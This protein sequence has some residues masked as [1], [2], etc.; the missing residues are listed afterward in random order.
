MPQSI[1]K[2]RNVQNLTRIYALS[3]RNVILRYK[4]SLIGFLW[5]FI[6]PI[7]Y[8]GIFV[9]IFGKNAGIPHYVLYVTSGLVLWFF[10]SNVTGQ[11]VGTIVGSAGIL[12]SLNIPSYFFPLSEL[13][14]E[15]FNLFLT[16]G[17]FL[18]LMHW[19]GIVYSFRMLL[20]IPC[21][22][23]FA[24]FVY[25]LNLM[26]CSLNVFFRDVG[27]IWGTIQPAIFFLT[28]IGYTEK[29]INPDYKLFYQYNPVYYF[30]KLG[31]DIFY[32]T[33]LP[34]MH[35]W[36]KCMIVATIMFAIG[37]FIYDRLKNQF[38]SAI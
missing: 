5:G 26:L 36:V 18:I 9:V 7:L 21:I 1:N 2:I 28:P 31:R 33:T 34:P 20:I 29:N 12:K 8:L 19:A 35:L 13:I 11:T 38:I 24:V 27:I 25:G 30:I 10:F 3:K 32:E 22:M 37:Q 14:G 16:L 17:V 6:K 4:S 23:L 15:L